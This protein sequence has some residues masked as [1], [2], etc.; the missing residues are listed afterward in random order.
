MLNFVVLFEVF[1]ILIDCVDFCVIVCWIELYFIVFDFGCGDGSLLCVLQDELDV[2]VYGIEIDDVGVL[3]FMKKGVYVIQQN[4]EGGLVLFEDKS[5]DMVIL[6]QMFQIIYNMVQV[7]C[8]MLWVGCECIVLFLNFGY[9]L[10][11]LL[12]FCGCMLV[13][14]L[15]LYEWYNMFNVCVLI[16]CDFEVLVFKVG[17][18]IFDCVVLYEGSVVCWGVNWCGSVVVYWVCVG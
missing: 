6:L 16:I 10:Y 8:E 3:V 9:W 15:L 18:V 7:L 13:F 12:I 2:L 11:W 17:L 4:M 5:F 14:K 1:N